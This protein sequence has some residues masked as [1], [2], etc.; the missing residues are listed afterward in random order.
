MPSFLWTQKQDIGAS[1]RVSHGVTF[2]AERNRV[3]LFGGDPGGR[4]LAD[5]WS[6]DGSLWTQVAD[7]GPLA[8]RDLAMSLAIGPDTDASGSSDKLVV[9]FG[10][11]SG[12]N[13]FADT[14]IWDGTEWTQVA[15][16]G[17]AARSSHSL[18]YDSARNRVVLF[19]GRT[20]TN[21][22]VG[23]TWE[24]DGTEWTQVQDV[25]P[26][27]RRAHAMAFDP[28][29][30]RV[31]LFGGAGANNEGLDDTWLWNGT[32]WTQAAD[33]GPDPRAGSAMVAA[34][35][36]VLFGGVNSVDP[37]LPTANR[38]IYG[39]SWRWD[40]RVWTKVQ[41]IG[42]APRWG[43]GM[44]F[45]SDTGRIVL[46]GGSSVFGPA[47]DPSLQTGVM[48]DTWEHSEAGQTP[49]PPGS[50]LV[51][52]QSV[53]A[54]YIQGVLEVDVVLTGPAPVGGV[55]LVASA[56][57]PAVGSMAPI[58]V[59]PIAAGSAGTHFGVMTNLPAGN[60]V[61]S[62]AVEGGVAQTATFAV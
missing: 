29:A 36:I 43:H 38:I 18:A 13:L 54:T 31:V 12:S 50:P 3:L 33:T 25:G 34:T 27:A 42:P 11:A 40:G 21:S 62:V 46:V 20:A 45:R 57:D 4:P 7:T 17:P 53:A 59:P 14:W 6:W 22:V 55:N 61:L 28:T 24:W 58:A 48:G 16:T 32:D 47:E 26:S 41:D 56:M 9:L 51:Q 23:D 30:S 10:G 52:V 5:T 39:D 35:T 2:D 44:A 60:Y 1:S 49:P 15:D 37:N 8:R 19:G